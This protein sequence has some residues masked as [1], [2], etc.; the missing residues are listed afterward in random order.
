MCLDIYKLN[1]FRKNILNKEIGK[2]FS[3]IFLAT[4]RIGLENSL[5]Y[6]IFN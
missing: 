6:D 1:I 5:Y 3:I 4:L 2:N